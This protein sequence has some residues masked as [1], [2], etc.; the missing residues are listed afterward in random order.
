VK[1]RAIPSVNTSD[2]VINRVQDNLLAGLKAI[3]QSPIL[4]GSLLTGVILA[5]GDNTIRH[6][7]GSVLSGWMVVRQ[8]GAA[9]L[10]DKQDSNTIPAS[11]LVLNSSAAVT[12]D[13]YVF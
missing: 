6:G 9:T 5:S 10:Y 2:P 12:V 3:G 1:L 4:G 13:L 8:R 11:T 7:L